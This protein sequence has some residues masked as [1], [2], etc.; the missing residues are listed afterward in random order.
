MRKQFSNYRIAHSKAEQSWVCSQLAVGVTDD[1][2]PCKMMIVCPISVRWLLGGIIR[3]PR[4]EL[5]T[6]SLVI[7]SKV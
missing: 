7:F 5:L 1:L 3:E 4:A 6:T 2:S